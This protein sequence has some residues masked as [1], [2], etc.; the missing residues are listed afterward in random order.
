MWLSIAAHKR[1]LAVVIACISPVKW[2]FISSIG[3]TCAYPPPA[4]PP[5]IPKTGPKDGSLNATIAFLFLLFNACP[6]PIVTVDLPSP[7]G[8]GLI[9]VT[10]TSFPFLLSLFLSKTSKDILH[11]YLPYWSISSSLKF[12]S[13]AISLIFFILASWAICIS[14]FI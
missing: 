14:L 12:N 2:R 4:A 1:L 7:A 5:F 10:N 9:A 6:S 3:T 13:A 8:V 11:L